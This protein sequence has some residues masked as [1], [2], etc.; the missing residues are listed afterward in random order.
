MLSLSKH[1]YRFV[2]LVTK[3]TLAVEMLRQA[4]H[5]G[6]FIYCPHTLEQLA[7]AKQTARYWFAALR[8]WRYNLHIISRHELRCAKLTLVR[9]HSQ[10]FSVLLQSYRLN[11]KARCRAVGAGFY[12]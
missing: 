3:F 8:Q 11:V 9:C 10:H 7:F 6:L 4:Q 12:Y 1:L 5:D 2:E